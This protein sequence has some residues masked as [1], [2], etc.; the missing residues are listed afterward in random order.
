MGPLEAVNGSRTGVWSLIKIGVLKS[1]K[2]HS[3]LV[4][5]ELRGWTVAF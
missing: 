1:R 3:R 4:C 5:G 2:E